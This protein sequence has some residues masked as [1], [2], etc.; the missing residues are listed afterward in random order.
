MADGP[1]MLGRN[2]DGKLSMPSF[3]M[4]TDWKQGM[5]M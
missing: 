3:G 5:G 2:E 4:V 1:T